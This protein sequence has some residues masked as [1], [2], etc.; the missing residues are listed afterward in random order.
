[1]TINLVGVCIREGCEM[2][3]IEEDLGDL[4]EWWTKV[5]YTK[6]LAEKAKEKNKKKALI[7]M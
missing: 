3:V 4:V 1:M 7:V 2:S 5:A 6:Q